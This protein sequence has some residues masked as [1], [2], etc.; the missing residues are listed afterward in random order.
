LQ[1]AG[2]EAHVGQQLVRI[3]VASVNTLQR[4]GDEANGDGSRFRSGILHVNSLRDTVN[5]GIRYQLN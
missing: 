1:Q 4:G 5:W 3:E 2:R